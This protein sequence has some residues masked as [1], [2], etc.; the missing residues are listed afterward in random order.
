M[1]FIATEN[2]QLKGLILPF[3]I[4]NIRFPSL[5]FNT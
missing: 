4:A 3:L 1:N 2:Q 5:L